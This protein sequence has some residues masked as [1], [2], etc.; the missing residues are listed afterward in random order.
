M[1]DSE[2]VKVS[3]LSFPTY[4]S[5][6]HTSEANW[7]GSKVQLDNVAFTD[8]PLHIRGGTVLPLRAQSANTTTDLRTRDFEF[9][10]APGT[11]G[12]AFGKLYVDDGVSVAPATTTELTLAYAAGTLA[13]SGRFGFNTGVKTSRVR[14]LGV[15][16][17]PASVKINGKAVAKT[18]YSYDTTRQVLDVTVGLPLTASL[19][20]GFS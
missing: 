12:A 19:T 6:N 1:D 14:F 7:T 20:V 2:G 11:N 9:V 4:R 16:K 17:A 10:V 15:S 13:V 8:I 5:N 3:I 18:L